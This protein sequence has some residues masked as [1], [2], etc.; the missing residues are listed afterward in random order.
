VG[1]LTECYPRCYRQRTARSREVIRSA[2]ARNE[3]VYGV[4]TLFGGMADQYGAP[5]GGLMVDF[6]SYSW[7]GVTAA[8]ACS[9][10][11]PAF[12]PGL[13]RALAAKHASDWHGSRDA[14]AE[15]PVP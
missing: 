14:Q 12:L 1:G 11:A 15:A 9:V 6:G 10:I 2:I 7:V 8:I 4:T 13:A 5:L 3:Q